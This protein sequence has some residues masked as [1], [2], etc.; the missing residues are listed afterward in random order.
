LVSGAMTMVFVAIMFVS[1]IAGIVLI[2]FGG[3]GAGTGAGGGG[4]GG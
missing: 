4:V 3:S 2:V 1:I